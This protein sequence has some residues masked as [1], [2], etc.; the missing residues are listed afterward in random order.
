MSETDPF[1]DESE[2][3]GTSVEVTLKAGSGYDAPWIRLKGST[4][5]EVLTLMDKSLID[6]MTET[7]SAGLALQRTYTAKQKGVS[8]PAGQYGKPAG[9]DKKTDVDLPFADS[10]V[11]ESSDSKTPTC[12]HGPRKLVT[13]KG[14][15]GWVCEL[16]KGTEG[17]CDTVPA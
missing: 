7:A 12:S 16:P 17:R 11:N 1:A 5:A 4:P 10:G 2:Q 9:A 14:Q 8:A 13:Y 3:E 6:L 15:S